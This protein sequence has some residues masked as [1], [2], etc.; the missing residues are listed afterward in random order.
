M[1]SLVFTVEALSQPKPIRLRNEIIDTASGKNRA[2]MAGLRHDKKAVSGLYLLQFNGPIQPVQRAELK[3]LGVDLIRYVPDDAF[4][5]R[6]EKVSPATVGALSYIHWIGPYRTQHKIQSRLAEIAPKAA[7]SNETVTVNILLSASAS[8][9]ELAAVKSHLLVTANESHLRQGIIV[10]GELS[11]GELEALAQSSAVLWVERAP[12]RKLVDEAASKIVGGDDGKIATRTVTQQLGFDGSGVTVCVA[13]TGLD[14]GNTNTMHPD[15]KGRV[16]GFQFYPPLTDGSDGYG[17]GTHC[18]GIVAGN[19]ATGETDP[20]SGQLYGLG[21]ASGANI[22]VER[23]FDNDANEVNFTNDETLTHDAVRHGAKIGS[24]SWGNDVAG[25]YDIDCAQFDELVRDADAG[26]PGYQPYILEFSA[27]NAGPG[28]QTIGSPATAKNVIATGASDNVPGTLAE[29]YDLYADGIDTMADFSSR[30]PCADGR[31]KPD[32][33]APG[34]WIASA[35]SRSAP[36][37]ASIAWTA[38]D[39]FYVYMGGTSMSGP[40]AAGAAA[41]FVQFYQ[42]THTNAVPSPA[43]VKAALINSADELD[44]A[45]GGPSP[46]PNND[47]GWGRINLENIITTNFIGAPRAY[48]YVDQTVL[49]TNGQVYTQHIFVRSAGQPLKVTLAYTDVPGFPGAIPALV[50][51][52]DLEMVAP[53]GTLYRGN[54]FGAGESVPNAPTPDKLNNVE[55]IYL[56][57]PV[58][59]DYQVRVRGTKIV[60]DALT[61]TTSIDQDFALVASGDLS[62]AGQGLI[63]LDRPSYTVPGVMQMIVLD[64]TRAANI[65][66]GVLVKDITRNTAVSLGLSAA[67]NYGAFTGAVVTV[68]GTAGAGQLQIANGDMLEVDY[69]DAGGAIRKATAVADLVPPGISGVSVTTDLGVVT[70]TWTTTEPATSLVRYGTN[71][72]NLNLAVTNNTL[73][74]SHSVKLTRLIAGKTYYFA[75]TAADAAGNTATNNNAGA[76]FTLV[77]VATP[78]VLLVDDYDTAGEEAVGSPVIPDGAYTNVLAAAGVSYG[79]WKVTARGYPQ[80][81]DLQPYPVVI[82]RTTDDIVNYGVDEDGLPDPTATHDTL[83]VQQQFMIQTY[84]N[85]GGSFFMSSMSILT[86]LGG[87]PFVKNVLQ[88]GGFLQNPDPPAPDPSGDEDFGVPAVLGA[89]ATLANGLNQTLDYSQYP[90]FDDGF[91]DEFGPDFSD[92]FTPTADA[93]PIIFESASGKPC[94][95]SYPDNGVDSPGRVVFLTFPFDAIPAGGT[96]PNNAVT[97]MQNIIK[98]LA[99]G[100]NGT[101]VVLLDNSVYTTNDLVTV[102]VGDADLAGAGQTA[103]TFGASSRTNRTTVTL[104]ETTHPG[105]FKGVVTLVAG[106]AGTNQLRVQNGDVL[107]A[108]YFDASN[109]SNVTATATIDTIPPVISQVAAT[110]D[111]YNARVSWRTSKPADSS[112][113]YSESPLPDRSTFVS[114]LVTNHAVTI[115]GLSANRIY[116]YEVVSRDQAGN[117]TVDDNGGNLYTFQTLKAPTP[118][119]FDNLESGAPGWSVVPDPSQG[120]DINWTLGTPNNGLATKANSGTNAWGSNLTGDQNFFLASSFLYGPV[121]DL[122]GLTSATLTFSN[123]YD[124]SRVN[125]SLGFDIYEEDGGVFVSTNSSTP[126]SLGL[127]LLV[128]YAGDVADTW[129]GRTLDLTPF[130]G[131][132]IQVVFYYQAANLGDTIYGWTLDDISITGVA[133]GGNIRITKNL[134]QG[135]WSLSSLSPIGLVPVQSGVAPAITLNNMAAGKYVLQFSDVPYY[136]TPA[137]STNTLAAGGT[138]NLAGTYDFQDANHNGISDSWEADKFGSVTTNRT[139]L[140]DTDHDGM[141]DYAE[142]I[143]GTSPTNAAS[144]LYFTGESRQS[145]GTIHFQW[146][147]VTNRLYQ[148]NASSNLQSWLSVT[149]WWQ[150]SNNPTMSFTATNTS[151]S[152]FYRVQVMP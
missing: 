53:D 132:T 52:L 107:T 130:V 101:G 78:T 28:T 148:V 60:Q 97:L 126:P 70:I 51:D 96:A 150:A 25:D 80:L 103:V 3:G 146:P 142:F 83:S 59:G 62:R 145:N 9:G 110:T 122:S 17:H 71:G 10:R 16:T 66:V 123:V 61:N 98:F 30:G 106:V 139:Q 82:W 11:P 104:F 64:A 36:D 93:T 12:K 90:S 128:D 94:G 45:N 27:G 87:V 125:S 48:Q 74:T 88:V 65:S 108:S 47:E 124:F 81:T 40:H 31:I 2:A 91:G 24:N 63:L 72:A 35:A 39:D 140:T 121:I 118:P 117:I 75:I 141:T 46:V 85:G 56:S 92:T 58:P 33:V 14:T 55:G 76:N 84:L 42:A 29:T 95:M 57:A 144:R 32:V 19:A 1:F 113:Q 37:E 15:L 115:S 105:L 49:L 119:W 21:V 41:V 73:V 5:A 134:G 137:D 133:A 23:I 79:F 50:N 4:I 129:Q 152:S 116:Y 68:T 99:P 13:D 18:A 34:T 43:L 143:A 67:G 69:V 136:Q 120:S 112:V 6:L 77:G 109:G 20:D 7:Q 89:T 22:F 151:K 100:A 111:Y 44:E 127:P 86:Q 149:T 54:Q 147:V 131:K 114:A 8:A 38:I 135:M 26:T 138:L 102:Q